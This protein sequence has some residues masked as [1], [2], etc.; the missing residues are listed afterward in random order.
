MTRQKHSAPHTRRGMTLVELTVAM[1]TSSVMFLAVMNILS[2]NQ[3]QFNQ[4]YTRVTG[5]VV[6]D[7]YMAERLFDRIVRKAS[8]DYISPAFH[9]Y[10][11]T[12]SSV[13]V[14]FYSDDT[15]AAPDKFARFDYDAGAH[16][17]LLTQ[18]DIGTSPDGMVIAR[19]VT[20]C[21]FTR[22]GPCVH[23]ALTIGDGTT[24]QTIAVTS[25]RHNEG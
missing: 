11:D 14:R 21:T 1:T 5:D 20:A 16:T 25:T 24:S 17:L 10:T 4:T 6:N 8:V 19:N 2:S 15:L 18:G 7:A 12:S 9:E 22:T 3:V 13:E 23:M